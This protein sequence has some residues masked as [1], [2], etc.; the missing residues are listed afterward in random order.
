MARR[1]L[2]SIIQNKRLKRH[3]EKPDGWTFFLLPPMLLAAVFFFCNMSAKEG[4]RSSKPA[5]EK[6]VEPKKE[7]AD[8]ADFE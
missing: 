4:K 8:T 5:A 1:S 3:G 7:A 6:K 2:Q